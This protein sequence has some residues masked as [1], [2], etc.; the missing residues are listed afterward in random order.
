MY[1]RKY[2]KISLKCVLTGVMASV[3]IVAA[4]I[5]TTE[6]MKVPISYVPS[7][8]ANLMAQFQAIRKMKLYLSKGMILPYGGT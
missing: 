3:V 5:G 6:L 1:L 7:V 8:T 4:F 2:E